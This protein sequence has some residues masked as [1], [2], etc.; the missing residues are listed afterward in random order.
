MDR[1]KANLLTLLIF[2]NYWGGF[3]NFNDFYS[4]NVQLWMIKKLKT[5]S[6]VGDVMTIKHLLLEYVVILWF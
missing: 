2:S 5:Y 3:E 1:T 6:V 4:E